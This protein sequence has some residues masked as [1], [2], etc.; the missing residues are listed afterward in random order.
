MAQLTLS[1]KYQKNT[2]LLLSPTEVWSM[3]LY[4]IDIASTDGSIFSND[5]MRMYIEAAQREIENRLNLRFVKQ[6]ID[7][8]TSYNRDD[9]WQQFPILKTKFPVS[10]PLS[11]VGMLNNIEQIIFPAVWLRNAQSSTGVN[12]RRISVVPTGSSTTQS[13]AEVILAGITTQI[14]FQTFHNIPDYWSIQYITGFDLDKTPMDLLNV[15][16]KLACFGP[17]NIGGDLIIGAGIASQSISVDGLS[18]SVGTTSSAENSGYSAR[19]KQYDREIKETLKYVEKI[20]N[21]VIFTVL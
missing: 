8:S 11:L 13:N 19:I 1:I 10:K 6:L 14:G 20:Y 5:A 17:L 21:E 3:Y 16:G 4:G 9:Y 15:V 12:K 2:G 7:E 18:Q